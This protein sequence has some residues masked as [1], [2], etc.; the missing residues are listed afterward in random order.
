MRR[1]PF[2]RLL[3]GAAIWPIVVARGRS[4]R[5]EPSGKASTRSWMTNDED[6]L[7]PQLAQFVGNKP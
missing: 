6:L 2:I 5:S 4:L 7:A 3:G 1:R